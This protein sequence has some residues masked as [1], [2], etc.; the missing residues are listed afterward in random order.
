MC[1]LTTSFWKLP[2][3]KIRNNVFGFLFVPVAAAVSCDAYPADIER[4]QQVLS[5]AGGVDPAVNCALCDIVDA[6]VVRKVL[7][8]IPV[9]RQ[10]GKPPVRP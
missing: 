9:R 6:A 4:P 1:L 7:P 3:L 5:V 10:P 2:Q 8:R